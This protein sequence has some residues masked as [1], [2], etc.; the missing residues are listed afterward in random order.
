MWEEAGVLGENPSVQAGNRHT[1]SHTITEDHG[2]RT[3]VAGVRSECYVHYATWTP[4]AVKKKRLNSWKR[5]TK[6]KVVGHSV[7]PFSSW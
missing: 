5:E 1:L 3:R 2:D 7:L 4:V 6:S